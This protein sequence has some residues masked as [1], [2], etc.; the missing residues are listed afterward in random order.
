M[1]EKRSCTPTAT[2]TCFAR[3]AWKKTQA[4]LSR[5]HFSTSFF[6][7]VEEVGRLKVELGAA[8]K[9]GFYGL[10]KQAKLGSNATP[11]PGLLDP[12]GGAK[13]DA[14][15]SRRGLAAQGAKDM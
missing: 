5:P 10:F 9:L 1:R 15:Y 13:W 4:S 7:Q 6:L 3:N 12:V 14:W 2:S 8:A 11:R